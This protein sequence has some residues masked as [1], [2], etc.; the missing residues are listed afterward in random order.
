MEQKPSQE[1]KNGS[2]SL[3]RPI[4]TE[5]QMRPFEEL[6]QNA[7]RN[8]LNGIQGIPNR[9]LIENYKQQIR[10]YCIVQVLP[11]SNHCGIVHEGHVLH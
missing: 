1:T 7:L 9:K 11:Y 3:H 5:Q 10:V 8:V 2:Y 6:F 4:K